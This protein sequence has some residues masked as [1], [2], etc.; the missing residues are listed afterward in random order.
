MSSSSSPKSSLSKSS[1]SASVLKAFSA[2]NDNT[3]RKV[4]VS[5][6]ESSTANTSKSSPIKKKR[7]A[8]GK[9]RNAASK[10]EP[11]SSS[12]G[13]SPQKGTVGRRSKRAVKSVGT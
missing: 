12:P 1:T 3:G 7:I 10:A 13:A 9:S 5:E 2:L 6:A 8:S 11:S 4:N